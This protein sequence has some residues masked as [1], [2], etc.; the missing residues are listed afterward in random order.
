MFPIEIAHVHPRQ[1]PRIVFDPQPL[2]QGAGPWTQDVI[3]VADLMEMNAVS[4]NQAR[5][6]GQ[7]VQEELFDTRRIS[8]WL[9]SPGRTFTP[10][11]QRCLAQCRVLREVIYTSNLQRQPSF[12]FWQGQNRATLGVVRTLLVGVRERGARKEMH[13]SHHGSDQ[14]FAM[15]AEVRLT[16]RPMVD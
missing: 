6:G 16:A 14:P 9:F 3:P 2:L 5:N 15:P 11:L 13:R 1:I 4:L 8:K 12:Q 7:E 10:S